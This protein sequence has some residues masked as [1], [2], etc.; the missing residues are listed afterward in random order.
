MPHINIKGCQV[1]IRTADDLPYDDL[2]SAVDEE[3]SETGTGENP[4]A[5]W[6]PD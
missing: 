1:L 5:P 4:Q 2:P 3:V 6:A